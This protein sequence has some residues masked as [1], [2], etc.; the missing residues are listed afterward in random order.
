M[1]LDVDA[2]ENGLGAVLSQEVD[3]QQV[4]AY[5]S[6]ALT[7]AEKK[8]CAT[9]K[10]LL[11]LV[12]GVRHFRLYLL[13]RMFIAR[14]DHNSLKWLHNFRDPEGHVGHWLETLAEY[15]FKMIHRQG[16]QHSNADALSRQ[17]C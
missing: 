16:S 9:K 3:G 11:A 15:N 17:P 4:V 5:G 2:S 14:T 12:W 13:G 10:E 6:R 8:Y 7:K 1:I